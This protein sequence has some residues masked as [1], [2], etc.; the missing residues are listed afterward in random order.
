MFYL[1]VK[2]AYPTGLSYLCQTSTREP[3]TYKGS[4]KR[5]L[6]HI[7]AHKPHIITCVIGEYETMEELKTAGIHYS[8]L[9]NVVESDDWANLRPED[10]MGGGTGKIG[11]RWKIKDTSRMKGSKDRTSEK[12]QAAYKRAAERMRA[13]NPMSDPEISRKV[14]QKT[15]ERYL[16]FG[17]PSKGKKM[18]DAAKANMRGKT[19]AKIKS[20]TCLKCRKE[21]DYQNAERHLLK[22]HSGL[23]IIGNPIAS[24]VV[25]RSEMPNNR[26]SLHKCW[27]VKEP[28]GN[29]N[30]QYTENTSG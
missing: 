18:S 14:G 25:C 11:R 1:M 20:M 6:N 30:R 10:G 17:S 26:L 27:K 28:H 23:K 22:C 15:R 24:C 29:L 16:E 8:E 2:K 4:G 9:F 5:W 19:R 13:N 3:Y 7:R 21:F 12:C